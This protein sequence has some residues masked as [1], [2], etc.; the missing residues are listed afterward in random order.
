MYSRFNVKVSLIA[1]NIIENSNSKTI[2]SN[3]I[4]KGLK[5]SSAYN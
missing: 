1:G 5:S 3:T 2:R 4:G